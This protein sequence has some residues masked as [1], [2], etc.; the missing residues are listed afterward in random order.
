MTT[1]FSPAE[2]LYEQQIRS[3]PRE[4]QLY[5]LKLIADGLVEATNE[6]DEDSHDLLEFEGVGEHNPVGMDAQK[7]VSKMRDEWDTRP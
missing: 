3:L 7:Y 4:G 5:L 2:A 6:P 1:T